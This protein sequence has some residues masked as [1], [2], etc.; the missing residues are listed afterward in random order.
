LMKQVHH[1]GL[2]GSAQSATTPSAD[3]PWRKCRGTTHTA[4]AMQAHECSE[5][6]YSKG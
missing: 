5:P 3:R 1:K 4:A 2:A 6:K